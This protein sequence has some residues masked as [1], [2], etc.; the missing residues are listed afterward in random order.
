MEEVFRVETIDWTNG[1]IK[2]NDSADDVKNIDLSC[3]HNLSGPI[4]VT[5]KVWIKR[6]F[7]SKFRQIVLECYMGSQY[8]NDSNAYDLVIPDWFILPAAHHSAAMHTDPPTYLLQQQIL[9]NCMHSRLK[10]STKAVLML[11]GIG[12]LHAFKRV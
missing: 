7:S 11:T 6:P 5:D 3:V 2:D 12:R 9:A 1:Q 4:A 10:S 8:C